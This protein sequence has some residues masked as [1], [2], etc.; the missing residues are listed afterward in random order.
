MRAPGFEPLILIKGKSAPSRYFCSRGAR[1]STGARS[2]RLAAASVLYF[3]SVF[4]AGLVLG[5]IRVF[6]LE[7]RIGKL[8]AVLCE[9]PFLLAA[10]IAAAL[11]VPA[12][13][14]SAKDFRSLAAIGVGALLLQQLADFAVASLLGLSASEQFRN[15]VSPAGFIYATLLLLFAAMPLLANRKYGRDTA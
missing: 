7:P 12:K 2:V 13:T 6:W 3:A 10:T 15:L 9:T 4:G 5:P 14:G 11:W 1:E 8:A